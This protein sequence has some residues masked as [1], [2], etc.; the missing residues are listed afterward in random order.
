MSAEIVAGLCFAV[1]FISVAAMTILNVLLVGETN[2]DLRPF[3]DWVIFSWGTLPFRPEALSPQGL[4]YRK[5]YLRFLVAFVASILLL[6]TASVFGA[7]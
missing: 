5:W 2:E 7:S 6:L 4:W 1:G 3:S